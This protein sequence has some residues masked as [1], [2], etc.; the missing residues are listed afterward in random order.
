[1][2]IG[3]AVLLLIGWVPVVGALVAGYVI[4][5]HTSSKGDAA[6]AGFVSGALVALIFVWIFFASGSQVFVVSEGPFSGFVGNF[7]TFTYSLGPFFLITDVVLL[8]ILGSL[9]GEAS[10]SRWTG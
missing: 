2:I 4:G 10:R 7:F 1:M 9:L 6:A 5:L 3:L 8:T